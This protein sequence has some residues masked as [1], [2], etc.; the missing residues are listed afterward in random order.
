MQ[1]MLPVIF[2]YFIFNHKNPGKL[3]LIL[4]FEGHEQILLNAKNLVGTAFP[5]HIPCPFH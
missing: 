1:I 5:A 3:S 2:K 4:L